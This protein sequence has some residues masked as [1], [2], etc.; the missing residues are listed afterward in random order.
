MLSTRQNNIPLVYLQLYKTIKLNVDID[1][2]LIS[3]KKLHYSISRF[4]LPRELREPII[5]ELINFKLIEKINKHCYNV[6]NIDVSLLDNTSKLYEMY[7]L[8]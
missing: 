3:H 5:K 7:E 8:Y 4:N 6:I 1:V 2:D